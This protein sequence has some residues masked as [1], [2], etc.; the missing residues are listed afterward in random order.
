MAKST[1]DQRNYDNLEEEIV[2]E[3]I[4]YVLLTLLRDLRLRV[5]GPVTGKEYFF[6]GAGF[7][8]YM[9]ERD[10]NE[11]VKKVSAK[12]CCSGENTRTPYFEIVR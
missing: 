9:D 6:D 3:P 5:L 7:S 8:V 1:D 2:E 4:Q 11:L 10:A 12:S